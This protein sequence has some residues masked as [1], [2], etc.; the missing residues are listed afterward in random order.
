[1]KEENFMSEIIPGGYEL[2][3]EVGEREMES[4]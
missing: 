4:Q 1:L 3:Q 2:H